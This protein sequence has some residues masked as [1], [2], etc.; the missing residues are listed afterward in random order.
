MKNHGFAEDAQTGFSDADAVFARATAGD[1]RR[2]GPVGPAYEVLG[3]KTS[4]D[5]EIYVIET[6]ERLDY[7]L[8]DF[9]ADPVTETIP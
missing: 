5:V 2:F 4:G 1:V 7:S 9:L 3:V 6:G 8:A